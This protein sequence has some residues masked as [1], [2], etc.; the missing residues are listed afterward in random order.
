MTH[1]R[2]VD[3]IEKYIREQR[4]ADLHTLAAR[5]SISQ[6]TARRALDELEARG[7]LRRHHG[8]ASVIDVDE[9][10]REYDFVT[11]EQDRGDEKF[12]MASL[13]AERV[14]PGMTVLI[15]GGT[16][17][18]SSANGSASSPT[19]SPSPASSA[20]YPPSKPS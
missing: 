10:A 7:V 20:T 3:L 14:M 9:I 8:G 19:L 13:I 12:A 6:S 15:D 1:R 4:Y 17:A 5:F 2:R 16:S 11:H 18:C